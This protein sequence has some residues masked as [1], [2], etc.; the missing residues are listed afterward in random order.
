M[1]TKGTLQYCASKISGGNMVP[2]SQLERFKPHRHRVLNLYKQSLRQMV[3]F[4]S[5]LIRQ[6]FEA[7]KHVKNLGKATELLKDGEEE[8]WI[9]QGQHAMK[10]LNLFM[11][12]GGIA[13]ERFSHIQY[14]NRVLGQWGAEEW[15]RY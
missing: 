1:G 12:E 14:E 15:A 6:R 8:Y 7:N 4:E 5:T 2:G 11:S 10:D 3:A 13:H 9:N